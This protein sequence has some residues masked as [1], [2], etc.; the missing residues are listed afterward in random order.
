M[1]MNILGHSKAKTNRWNGIKIVKKMIRY[2]TTW[3][4]M[5]VTTTL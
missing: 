4:R 1:K 3:W 2:Y 5:Q